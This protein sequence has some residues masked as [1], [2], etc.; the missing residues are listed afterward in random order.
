M[1]VVPWY[2]PPRQARWQ[3]PGPFRRTRNSELPG[4]RGFMARA[5]FLYYF[6]IKSGAGNSGTIGE[7]QYFL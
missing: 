7:F 5:V 6:I 3:A 4:I 2:L 1:T